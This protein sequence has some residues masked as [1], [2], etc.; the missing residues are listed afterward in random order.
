[1]KKIF[2]FT[3]EC[4]ITSRIENAYYRVEIDDKK[5]AS[6]YN[7]GFLSAPFYIEKIDN[8]DD[9]SHLKRYLKILLRVK[10]MVRE[11]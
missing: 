7:K 6:F 1:M 4:N 9:D 8:V 3:K 5:K 2:L 10:V 11:N